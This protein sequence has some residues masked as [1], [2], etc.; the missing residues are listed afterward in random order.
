MR[1]NV[2]TPEDLIILKLLSDREQDKLDA[3]KIQKIQIEHI[4]REY[5]QKWLEKIG[6]EWKK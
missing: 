4:N 1:F 3:K 2:A 5:L 6:I